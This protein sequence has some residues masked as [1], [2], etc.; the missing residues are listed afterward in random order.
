M[1]WSPATTA[2]NTIVKK[3]GDAEGGDGPGPEADVRRTSRRCGRTRDRRPDAWPKDLTP[4]PVRRGPPPR[5][6]RR[7]GGRLSWRSCSARRATPPP[8]ATS[9]SR[10]P[11]RALADVAA[12]AV[13]GARR[14]PG[15]S[16]AT[17]QGARAGGPS[18]AR[19]RSSTASRLEASTTPTDTGENAA[20]RRLKREEKDVYDRG[21]APARRGARRT[22]RRRRAQG[23]GRARAARRRRVSGRRAGREGRPGRR[24][25]RTWRLAAAGRAPLGLGARGD[26]ARRRPVL[27][28][29][30]LARALGERRAPLAVAAA[31]LLA[32]LALAASRRSSRPGDV[33]R[34]PPWPP[35]RPSGRR[36]TA[37]RDVGRPRAA[38]AP[39][40]AAIPIRRAGTSACSARRAGL[41]AGRRRRS[42]QA[43]HEARRALA[44][45]AVLS[46]ASSS[47]SS[48]SGA[49]SRFADARRTH[50]QAYLYVRPA[51][52]GML[53]LVFFPFLYGIA[54]SFTDQND[55]QHERARSPRSGSASRTTSRS[56][57]TS[58]SPS[59]AADGG[60]VFNYQNFY[61]TLCSRCSGRSRTSRSA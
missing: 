9:G 1:V 24:D 17:W 23:R 7:R 30:G 10:S 21:A 40:T 22:A 44:L 55:L 26:R 37:L 34:R 13:G 45:V 48:A 61:W 2:M 49:P 11:S 16:Y 27:L 32:G 33:G 54:I 42:S 3:V 35:R 39:A 46:L 47:P 38:P 6:A 57:P 8:R 52:V 4:A 56:S 5:H 15:R 28:F 50:R 53:V 18:D 14:A 58:G 19:R 51:M 41:D 59:R 60:L 36:S 12:A 25:G 20:P 29:L 43:T 31:L